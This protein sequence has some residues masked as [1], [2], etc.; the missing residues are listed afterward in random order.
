MSFQS[1]RH[2]ETSY[3][4]TVDSTSEVNLIRLLKNSHKFWTTLYVKMHKPETRLHNPK[5]KRMG[6]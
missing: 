1:E 5:T 4:V 3:E 6:E 2:M